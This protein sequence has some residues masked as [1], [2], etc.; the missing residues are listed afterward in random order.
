MF[1][2]R[3]FEAIDY[4]IAEDPLNNG[5]CTRAA[6]ATGCAS[7]ARLIDDEDGDGGRTETAPLETCSP[8]CA[9]ERT[10]MVIVIDEHGGRSG[11]VT[12]KDLFEE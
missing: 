1:C 8:P 4:V 9:R 12:L 10:Q 11:I 6:F 2:G 7:R 5:A 3:H